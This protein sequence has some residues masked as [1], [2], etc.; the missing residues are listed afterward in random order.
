M[1]WVTK[2]GKRKSI[3]CRCEGRCVICIGS[4]FCAGRT[5]RFSRQASWIEMETAVTPTTMCNL[6]FLILFP[7]KAHTCTSSITHTHAQKAAGLLLR[8][9]PC[10]SGPAVRWHPSPW[11]QLIASLDGNCA[12]KATISPSFH[13]LTPVIAIA[14][15]SFV[16]RTPFLSS[17][18]L[19]SC[20]HHAIPFHQKP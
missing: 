8:C 5:L 3:S 6:Q 10:Q 19:L 12:V 20:P 16:L 15:F 14:A 2:R 11:R 1:Q 9:P 18:L 13:L 7:W 4:A 17:S